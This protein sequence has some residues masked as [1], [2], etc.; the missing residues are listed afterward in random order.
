MSMGAATRLN[1]SLFAANIG[2]DR[3][4]VTSRE[5]CEQSK[6]NWMQTRND[7]K[8]ERAKR[9]FSEIKCESREVLKWARR[10]YEFLEMRCSP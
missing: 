4:A 6:E 7:T 10:K 2:V 5:P 3:S 8:M 1:R 9:A